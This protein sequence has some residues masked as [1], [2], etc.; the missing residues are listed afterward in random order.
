MQ[1]LRNLLAS[2][3]LTGNER[4]DYI[5]FLWGEQGNSSLPQDAAFKLFIDRKLLRQT[6]IDAIREYPLLLEGE[7]LEE[8]SRLLIK[9]SKGSILALGPGVVF[10]S[11]G[12]D[13]SLLDFANR[14]AIKFLAA[15]LPEFI[16]ASRRKTVW[17][18]PISEVQLSGEIVSNQLFWIPGEANIDA[19]LT[20]F[21]R[22]QRRLTGNQF[23][24]WIGNHRS[25]PV[26]PA[27]SWIGCFEKSRSRAESAIQAFMGAL[28]MA[29]EFPRAHYFTYRPSRF[30]NG[31]VEVSTNGDC[32][33][34]YDSPL[35]LPTG[36]GSINVS[37]SMLKMIRQ[38]VVERAADHRVQV[39]LEY[40]AAGWQPIGRI[41]FLHN[42]IA[43]DALFG[44]KNAVKESI[45]AGLATFAS[46]IDGVRSR[47]ELLYKM[48]NRL[49]HGESKSLESC[50]EYLTYY[51]TF[52]IDPAY[53]QIIILRTCLWEM[54]RAG[55]EQSTTGS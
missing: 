47:G 20:R 27:D 28:S 10:A 35:H 39:A 5:E 17:L 46:K 7:G 42:A 34:Q 37:P 32:T 29:I 22:F 36:L 54:S 31:H 44:K 8:V 19:V 49:L 24:P 26:G 51:E 53:D 6:A 38:L 52:E 33:V 55:T 1:I 23:P 9:F 18:V 4:E 40:I 48:R 15:S 41:G 16:E 3:R 45:L 2:F 43:F 13:L 14:D 12:E 30:P 25:W 50:P 21:G 11:L